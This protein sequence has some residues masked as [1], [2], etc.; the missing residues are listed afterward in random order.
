VGSVLRWWDYD[1]QLD[2]CTAVEE[3]LFAG[4]SSLREPAATACE[5]SILRHGG[6]M[7]GRR[8]SPKMDASAESSENPP[9]RPGDSGCAF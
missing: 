1:Q 9:K 7:T 2:I 5:K 3:R 4:R 6:T 8:S